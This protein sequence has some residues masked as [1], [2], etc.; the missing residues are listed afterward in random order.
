MS[1]TK[2][3]SNK[4]FGLFFGVVF[5]MFFVY[6]I[7]SDAAITVSLFFGC[8]FLTFLCLGLFKPRVLSPLKS[9]WLSFGNVLHKIVSPII[10]LAMFTVLII[11]LGI[12][13]RA[14]KRDALRLRQENQRETWVKSEPKNYS[15]FFDEQY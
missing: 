6:S 8:S 5:A 2:Q 14:V 13:F 10:I 12:F 4:S 7:Y 1:K 3:P 11:P 9:A 15:T